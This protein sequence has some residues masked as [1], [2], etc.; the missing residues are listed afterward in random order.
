MPT[1]YSHYRVLWMYGCVAINRKIV[2]VVTALPAFG[3]RGRRGSERSCH[4]PTVT[5]LKGKGR[6][7]PGLSAAWD[8]GVSSLRAYGNTPE[9]ELDKGY[10]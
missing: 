5:K 9:R 3:R 4:L 8:P 2:N 6:D 7:C 10:L 1:S